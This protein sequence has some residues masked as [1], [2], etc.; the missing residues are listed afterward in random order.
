MC[1]EPNKAAAHERPE[2]PA[3]TMATSNAAAEHVVVGI[4][5]RNGIAGGGSDAGSEAARK[6]AVEPQHLFTAPHHNSHVP[7]GSDRSS[8]S[9]A[10]LRAQ[11]AL[12]SYFS[13]TSS[14]GRQV[15]SPLYHPRQDR[16]GRSRSCMD[17][18]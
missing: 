14:G 18:L 6:R 4:I 10:L 12:P 5:P 7:H 8:T 15:G 2:I 17:M 13:D 3:P 1:F 11:N 9:G 16:N